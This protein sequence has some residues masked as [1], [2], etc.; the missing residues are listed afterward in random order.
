MQK[1]TK[2][3]P[4]ALNEFNFVN[5][6]AELRTISANILEQHVIQIRRQISTAIG[7]GDSEL[8]KILELT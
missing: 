6:F 8:F 3:P 4:D 5:Y 2:L 7:S 1:K